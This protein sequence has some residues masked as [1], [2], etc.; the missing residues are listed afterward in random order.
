MYH[1]THKIPIE[2]LEE[3]TSYVDKINK[4]VARGKVDTIPVEM[5]VAHKVTEYS[6]GGRTFYDLGTAKDHVVPLAT[7]PSSR[8]VKSNV[9][10]W[11]TVRAETPTLKGWEF[12]ARYDFESAGDKTA[13]FCHASPNAEIPKEYRDY[14]DS[15]CDHCNKKIFRKN[16]FLVRH[17]T[18]GYKIVGRSCLKDFLG[19]TSPET[20]IFWMRAILELSDGFSGEED[21]E[22]FFSKTKEEFEDPRD[23]LSWAVSV[24]TKNGWVSKARAREE[25]ERDSTA[26]LIRYLLTPPSLGQLEESKVR[27]REKRE[28]FEPTEKDFKIADEILIDIDSDNGDSEYMEKIKKIR[29]FGAVSSN[30]FALW[31]SACTIHLR[32]EWKVIQKKEREIR[33][34]AKKKANEMA[35]S[36]PVVDERIELTGEIMNTQWREN[37]FGGSFKMI[38]LEDRGFRIWVTATDPLLG[39]MDVSD[40]SDDSKV[41][42]ELNGKK[43]SF[44]ARVAR[45][46]DDEKFG[47]ATRPT[48]WAK[49]E[50]GNDE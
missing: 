22:S 5:S 19:H 34:A 35:E 12:L 43:V 38:L 30:N 21:S 15:N 7:N 48:K 49:V 40:E 28:K 47:F 2:N 50:E 41:A 31:I 26:S 17:E 6:V 24:A 29:N 23:L 18:K 13:V 25:S 11:A 42:E 1:A 36:V 14:S 39:L 32:K 4:R 27:W 9:F 16:V 46:R 10:V 3:L 8:V 33:E 45:S 37:D 44:T 20:I